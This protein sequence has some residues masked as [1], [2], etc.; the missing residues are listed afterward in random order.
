MRIF[1]S[2]IILIFGLQS[3]TNADDISDFQ[4][5]GMS[6]GD[7]LLS[8]VNKSTIN[9]SRKYE[10]N[11]DK[12]YTIDLILDNFE[13]YFG[14]QIHLKKNDQNYKIHG[15]GGAI[16]FG[17]PGEYYPQSINDCKKQM[18]II[19]QDLDKIFLNADKQS[20]QAVGQGDYDPDA[21]RDEIYYTI[22]NGYIYLQCVTWGSKRKK[23]DY[24][25]DSLRLTLLSLEFFNWI[26][27]EAYS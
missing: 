1:L 24:L 6:I 10:Y 23:K 17:E 27:N 14:V 21:V 26:E 3:S 5:E 25:Y 13:N 11:D 9:N 12:F 18:N 16:A 2:I 7:S 4:I 8:Y 22:E 19:E 20:A 15:I